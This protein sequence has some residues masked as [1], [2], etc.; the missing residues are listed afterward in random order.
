M[1]TIWRTLTIVLAVAFFACFLVGFSMYYWPGMP[2]SPQ[3][4][5]GRIYA[6]NNHG[7]YTYM[8]ESEH[9]LW[10]VMWWMFP[11]LILSLGAIIHFVDPFNEKGRPRPL[12]PPHPW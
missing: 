3:P 6:L 7:H 11:V 12:R 10:E 8:N 1:R 2:T 4:A 5:E 9:L